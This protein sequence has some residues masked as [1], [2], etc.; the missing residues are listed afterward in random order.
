MTV[1]FVGATMASLSCVTAAVRSPSRCP[2][3][4]AL[5]C[6]DR[7]RSARRDR[8]R[9]GERQGIGARTAPTDAPALG[10]RLSIVGSRAFT[11]D[12]KVPVSL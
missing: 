8:A 11:T 10:S 3:S 7:D 4:T 6:R 2:A 1:A 12:S 9:V 5:G